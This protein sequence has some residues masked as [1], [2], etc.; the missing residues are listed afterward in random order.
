[1][2]GV[3]KYGEGCFVSET[4]GGKRRHERRNTGKSELGDAVWNGQRV[5][6]NGR[7]GGFAGLS[8]IPE[9]NINQTP[10][11]NRK[12]D[13]LLRDLFP[14]GFWAG[15]SKKRLPRLVDEERP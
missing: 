13:L 15:S 4:K 3:A 14:E 7:A 1:M 10:V 6:W 11:H 12:F 2:G 5:G 8:Q 9:E